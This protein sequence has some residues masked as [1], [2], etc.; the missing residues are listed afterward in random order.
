MR[1]LFY[2]RGIESLGVG[3]LM[4]ML[5]HHGHE[6]DLVFDPG[7]DDNLYLKVKP[8]RFMNRYGPLLER[9]RAF[10]P[11]LIAISSLT[12]LYPFAC[13]MTHM[14]KAKLG[15]PVVFGGHHAQALPDYVLANPDVDYVCIGEGE[16]PLLELANRL[17]RGEDTTTI[18]GI[19]AKRDG[20]I[21]ETPQAPLVDDL[22]TLPFPEKDLWYEVGAFS[23]NLEVFTGRGC[24]FRCTYC[25]IHYQRAIFKDA[26]E[27]L[28]K[29]SVANVMEELRINVRKF[30]PR[31]VVLHD[32][33]FTPNRKWVEEFC[34]VYRQE[35]NLPWYCFGYP[36]TIRADVMKAMKAANCM[37]VFMGVDSGDPDLRRHL[38]ERPMPDEVIVRAARTI[39]DAGIGLH[40]SCI[41]GMPGE[42]PE[43][44][45]K[46]L[47]MVDAIRPDQASG[48]IFYPFPK[49]K[50]YQAAVE[51]GY[52]D[53]E[54]EEKVRQ[55]LSGYHHDSILKHPHKDLAVTF[56][57]LVPVYNKAPQS[58]RPLLR[59]VIE[60]RFKRLALLIYLIAFPIAFPFLGLEAVRITMRMAWKSLTL[61][62]RRRRLASRTAAGPPLLGTSP[63]PG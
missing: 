38:M 37:T 26:G 25:N 2:Y 43:Q 31:T 32:D 33:N 59:R 11:D 50:M 45:W 48:Y 47:D 36:T 20:R 54:G 7:F 62:M 14:L 28:R 23:R 16:V 19:W 41:F 56:S 4:S 29:R 63:S 5:K 40:I 44:M 46:T 49:T 52:L 13:E 10:A 6:V 42:R 35:I 34:E 8:L 27:F 21:V 1:V 17:E 22:D 24:P 30:D 60:H 12:N 39:Q 53:A 3:Y 9:A 57:K 55:G 61:P 18:P 51:Q 15:A 58:L